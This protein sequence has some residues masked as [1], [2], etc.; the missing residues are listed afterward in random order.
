[1]EEY[2]DLSLTVSPSPHIKHT[3]RTR[4]IMYDVAIALF[5]AILFGVYNF[6]LRVLTLTVISVLSCIGFEALWQALRKQPLRISDGSSL[7]TGLL[8]A[9]NLPVSA[10][11]WLPVPGALFAIILVKE[12]FG[13]I[14]KNI[15]NPALAARV[16]LFFSFPAYMSRYTVSLAKYSSGLSGFLHNGLPAFAITPSVDGVT[17]ATPLAQVMEGMVPTISGVGVKEAVLGFKG[18][19]IGEVS[20][21]FLLIGGVYLLM[22]RVITWHIPVAYLGTVAALALI[23]APAG[24]LSRMDFCIYFLC[25]GGLML[26]AL[27]MATDYVTS[28]LTAKGKLLY[29][30]G[31]GVLTVF[32]RFFGSYAEGVS[33]AVLIMNLLVYYI[34]KITMPKPFGGKRS[35]A[36]N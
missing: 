18:G 5:P 14:G 15:V 35:H 34:D 22:R 32:L 1:M 36:K 17:C 30:F 19:M 26:A 10:P 13:G 23:F 27:F 31:C 11:L 24:E 3:E 9:C 33:F 12:L 20:A 21:V 28:P 4:S 29:G 2:S 6:G 25:S 7:V 8:L 16:F